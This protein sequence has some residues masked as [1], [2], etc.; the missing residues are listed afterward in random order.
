MSPLAEF[1]LRS[2]LSAFPIHCASPQAMRDTGKAG[3]AIAHLQP[4]LSCPSASPSQAD[5]RSVSASKALKVSLST[6]GDLG[7]K[8]MIAVALAHDLPKSFLPVYRRK[9]KVDRAKACPNSLGCRSTVDL[10]NSVTV[11]GRE[12]RMAFQ[13]LRRTTVSAW[14]PARP[15]NRAHFAT[16]TC[17]SRNDITTHTHTQI[18][19]TCK[20]LLNLVVS[21]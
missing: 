11:G 8:A 12:A 20:C 7:G 3:Q 9:V 5:C 10:A 16:F 17:G 19:R 6:W 21:D 2:E 1:L 4:S 18:L 15:S 13:T 14:R